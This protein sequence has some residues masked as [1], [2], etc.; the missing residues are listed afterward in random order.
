MEYIDL[1]GLTLLGRVLDIGG[2]GEG[3][4]SRVVGNN[5]AAIDLR[6]D[7]LAETPDIGVKI[8]MDACDLK[9]ID[10]YFNAVTCFYSLMYMSAEQ[11]ERF[12]G[13]AYRVMKPGGRLLIWDVVIPPEMAGETFITEIKIKINPAEEISVGYGVGGVEEQTAETMQSIFVKAGFKCESGS[14]E[15]NEN[16]QMTFVK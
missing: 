5:V 4:I 9:F 6:A 2:G 12:A 15:G 16:F 8:I 13:E 1:T 3:V 11:I 10:E 14:G 7:E